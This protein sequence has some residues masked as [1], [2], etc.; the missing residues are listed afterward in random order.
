MSVATQIAAG[1]FHAAALTHDGE[2]Y[3]W[4]QGKLGATGHGDSERVPLPM[5]VSAL[6]GVRIVEV[7]PHLVVSLMPGRPRTCSVFA[8]PERILSYPPSS[9]SDIA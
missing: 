8:T 9:H 6:R 7:R 5:R 1:G 4:G 3:T 2:V